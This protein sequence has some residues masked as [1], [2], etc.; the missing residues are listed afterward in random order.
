ME[1]VRIAAAAREAILA[2]AREAR[3]GECCGLLVGKPGAI[4]RAVRA[5]NLAE[6]STRYLI[7]PVDHISVRRAARDRGLSV[8]GFYHSHPLGEPVPSPVDV[9][10][11]SYPEAIYLIA[12]AG[13]EGPLS[14]IRAYRISRDRQFSSV[15]LAVRP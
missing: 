4:E 14:D 15:T 12:G 11:A 10:E 8:L 2:H 1:L 3:P 6:E 7:D 5:R 13:P 9:D